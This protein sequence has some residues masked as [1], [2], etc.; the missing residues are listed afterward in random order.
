M[1]KARTLRDTPRS[2]KVTNNKHM[3]TFQSI[4]QYFKL[5]VTSHCGI[6]SQHEQ[7]RNKTKGT[8]GGSFRFDDFPLQNG[9]NSGSDEETTD[10][11]RCVHD[12]SDYMW[13]QYVYRHVRRCV[14]TLG[15][16]RTR[17]DDNA[18]V[19]SV[20][21]CYVDIFLLQV[22]NSTGCHFHS[23]ANVLRNQPQYITEVVIQRNALSSKYPL[24]VFN[25][26]AQ[27]NKWF[28]SF[29][30]NIYI[31]IYILMYHVV[32]M[33]RRLRH[34]AEMRRCRIYTANETVN[35]A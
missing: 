22:S 28:E 4:E 21:E 13:L 1:H 8:V 20:H 15:R 23:I 33:T 25:I 31:Y 27:N 11:L 32:Y 9:G 14:H 16:F 12:N 3:W 35:L 26:S 2:Q 24:N 17:H 5:C 34:S 18:C 6:L 30:Y 19:D 10:C 7:K 29:M